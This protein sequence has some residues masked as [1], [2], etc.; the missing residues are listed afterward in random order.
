MTTSTTSREKLGLVLGLIGVILFGGTLP[1]TRLAVTAL[2]PL[3][4]TATRATVAGCAG[5]VLLVAL[6]RPWPSRAQW[7]ILALAGAC[8]IIGFPVLMALAMANVPAA[9]GG[10]VL[11]IMPL[12]TV[13]AATLVTQ[14]RPSA[15]FWLASAFGAAIVIVFMLRHGDAG[16]VGLGD[17]FLLGTVIA[18]GFGYSLSGRL[19]KDMPGW[20]VISWQV[21]L[22]LPFALA[23]MLALWPGDLSTVPL[24]AWGGLAYVSFISQFF[25][26]FVF[27]AGM[28]MGGVAR[29][30]QLSLLQ[31]FVIVALAAPVNGE[32]I[33]ASTL[34]YAAAVVAAVIV[35]QRM[36]VGRR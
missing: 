5:L 3:F 33:E 1:M 2:D 27:N 32:P 14:E 6:R 31:P 22:Y 30:G 36:R 7:R 34:G 17:L 25:A 26:F 12:A 8:T 16:G 29:V 28:A 35:G 20:E 13:A 24:T 15:G 21:A 9:H 23:A 4:L 11:G 19:S 18:G 10:V